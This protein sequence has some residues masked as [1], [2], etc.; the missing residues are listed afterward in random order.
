M[1]TGTS[2]AMDYYDDVINKN[3]TGNNSLPPTPG[4]LLKAS[5][6]AEERTEFAQR[7]AQLQQQSSRGGGEEGRV[8]EGQMPGSPLHPIAGQGSQPGVPPVSPNHQGSQ[9]RRGMIAGGEDTLLHTTSQSQLTPL[10]QVAQ[11]PGGGGGLHT[12]SPRMGSQSAPGADHLGLPGGRL[13][14]EELN[15]LTSPF[16]LS[17][18]AFGSA[19]HLGAG[20]GRC[21]IYWYK[22]LH[23][24]CDHIGVASGHS[25]QP[26]LCGWSSFVYQRMGRCV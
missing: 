22:P 6:Q 19:A 12:P 13:S 18:P 15:S 20:M 3:S 25:F 4:A 26:L 14:A 7:L 11:P 5:L 21:R 23:L 17:A 24:Q 9:D 10:L 8:G 16:S 2:S 1:G